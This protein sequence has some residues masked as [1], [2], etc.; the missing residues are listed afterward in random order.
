M[1][2]VQGLV[3]EGIRL[4]GIAALKLITLGR[5]RSDPKSVVAEGGFGLLLIAAISWCAYYSWPG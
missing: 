1:S 5:Y 3:E 2:E 4:V